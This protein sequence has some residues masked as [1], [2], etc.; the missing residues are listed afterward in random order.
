MADGAGLDRSHCLVVGTQCAIV[1]V[2]PRLNVAAA[3]DSIIVLDRSFRCTAAQH[4]K[5]SVQRCAVY[6]VHCTV[7]SVHCTLYSVHC[8]LIKWN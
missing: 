4:T 6:G 7:F 5:C 8:I 3:C 1:T 2:M